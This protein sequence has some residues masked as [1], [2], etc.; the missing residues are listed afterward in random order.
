MK[1]KNDIDLLIENFY[2]CLIYRDYYL[3]SLKQLTRYGSCIVI[4]FILMMIALTFL[5]QD[6]KTIQTKFFI[7]VIFAGVNIIFIFLVIISIV[8]AVTSYTSV[9]EINKEINSIFKTKGQFIDKQYDNTCDVK[10]TTMNLQIRNNLLK[11]I[12]DSDSVD[13]LKLTISSEVE[14]QLRNEII[15]F[16][17]DLELNNTVDDLYKTLFNK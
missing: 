7:A 12:T 3:R 8:I 15:E 17:K 16:S 5:F 9:K 11:I 6:G 14:R 4:I 1:Q 2:V 10:S 13:K